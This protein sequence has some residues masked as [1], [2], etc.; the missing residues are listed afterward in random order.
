MRRGWAALPVLAAVLCL[1]CIAPAVAAAGS[2]SGTVTDV[3]SGEGIEEVEVCAWG[4]F[5]EDEGCVLTEANGSYEITDLLPDEYMVE[6]WSPDPKY[7]I[8]YFDHQSF[9][10]EAD[11]VIVETGA[12]TGIDAEL[13]LGGQIQGT[14]RAASTGAPLDEIEVCAWEVVNE[15]GRCT[16]TDP[17]GNYT[18]NRLVAGPYKVEFWDFEEVFDIQFWDHEA[19]WE[20]ADE[21]SITAG[22]AVNGINGDLLGGPP[23]PPVVTPPAVTPPAVTPPAVTPPAVTLPQVAKPKPKRCKKGFRKKKVK[24]KVRCVKVRK[25]HKNRAQ[26]SDARRYLQRPLR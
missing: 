24:G 9:P 13:V 10:W 17:A 12:V 18:L 3:V 23:P 26:K 14:V 5:E 7:A 19:F 16:S 1:A 21:I 6:F 22:G 25:R 4:F 2:I 15:A 8:Q 11:P 20:E